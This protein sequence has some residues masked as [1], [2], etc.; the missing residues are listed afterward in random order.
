MAVK[1][2]ISKAKR[3]NQKRN[4]LVKKGVIKSGKKAKF[5]QKATTIPQIKK[6]E[7]EES[8]ESDHGEDMLGMVEEDDLSFLKQAISNK[9]YSLLKQIRYN[10]GEKQDGKV[11]NRKRK[12]NDDE[13]ME[14]VYENQETDDIKVKNLLPIKTGKGVV[15][16]SML[17]DKVEDEDNGQANMEDQ[18]QE[19]PADEED[20]SENE[21]YELALDGFDPSIPIT[22]AD[23]LAAREEA[24]RTRKIH[25]GTLCSGLLENP[26]EKITNFK[27]LLKIMEEDTAEVYFTVRKLAT[28][29]LLE[30]FK[31][32]LPS[33]Q[34]KHY[35][36]SEVKLKKDT[37]Q[38]QKY[39]NVLL[40]YYKNYLQRLEKFAMVLV[41]KKGDSRRRT[42]DECKLAELAIHCMCDLLITHPYFNF[43]QNIAQSVVPFLN[44]RFPPVRQM[45]NDCCRTIFKEDKKGE[46]TLK[47]LRI[48]NQYLK[49]RAHN[50]N[51]EML[52]VLLALRIKEVNL[53]QEKEHELKQKKLMSHKQKLL[54]M[55]KKEKKRKK[56]L[57]AVEQELLETKAE[58]NK[59][60]KQKNLTEITKVVFGIYF[61]IL[62]SSTNTKVLGVCL[63]GLA[64]FS[65]CINLEFY[66][67]LVNVLNK[68]LKEDWLGY[69]EQLHCIQ[70]V[71]VMLSGQG[72]ALTLDPSRFYVTLYDKLLTTTA[73]K[74]H[75]DLLIV[76][77]TLTQAV[78]KRRKKVTH[79]RLIGFTKRLSTLSMQLLHNGTL[80]C[81]GMIKNIMQ[82]NKFTDVLLD[83]DTSVG[84]GKFF[85]ELDDPE[86]CN[87]SNT[88]LY[89]L[90][91]LSRHYHPTVCK[92]A[93]H[94]A[95]GVPAS[96]E[97][98]LAPDLGK[99]S[100]EELF[101][102][103]DPSRVEFNP[104]IPVPKKSQPKTKP[105]ECRFID[106]TFQ[107]YCTEAAK[108]KFK[109]D[110]TGLY[111]AI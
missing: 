86:Y 67:D 74:N 84:E 21:T 53:D 62:K 3:N 97:G 23:M 99:L 56:K 87:A 63:E 92:M 15:P 85:P 27:T 91:T 54:Q 44:H 107:D 64:K 83:L 17:D 68:L 26:E 19:E 22:T 75:K 102:K 7:P 49:N 81:L 104:S 66:S 25:I 65:H 96:G 100:P 79:Q 71:L 78:I 34:I 32:L 73:G 58:E 60:N 29:S 11:K 30:V 90:I 4:K 6:P 80:G 89:E 82:L 35:E 42:Q 37:L 10:S 20:D 52:D 41:K 93:R 38:L 45:V 46:I 105:K 110:E 31:D 95:N 13:T 61:R 47:I 40:Q 109:K 16:R 8:E 72:E 77:K 69:R 98:S 111:F 59:E 12:Q 18:Q 5:V 70:T 39:E 94:I 14:K 108:K 28:V 51:V 43:A 50:C 9:S 2:K 24:L 1:G 36:N 106:P 33:Y 101:E 76:L 55:S 48:I 103:Y 57:E 88:A